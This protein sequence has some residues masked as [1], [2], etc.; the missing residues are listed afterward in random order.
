MRH[1][2]IEIYSNQIERVDSDSLSVNNDSQP[3]RFA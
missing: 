3:I 1:L 2:D